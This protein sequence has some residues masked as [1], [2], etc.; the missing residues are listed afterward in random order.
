MQTAG[1]DKGGRC[2]LPPLIAAGGLVLLTIRFPPGAKT[3]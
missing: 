1:D 3:R 2:I